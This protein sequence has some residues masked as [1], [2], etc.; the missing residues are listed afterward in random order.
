MYYFVSNILVKFCLLYSTPF[1]CG[2]AW[3][4]E[5]FFLSLGETS[6]PKVL[7]GW[8][9]DNNHTVGPKPMPKFINVILDS[10]DI[11]ESKYL[12]ILPPSYRGLQK[13]SNLLEILERAK[14]SVTASE[15]EH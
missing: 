4:V 14:F 9:L 7:L 3:V 15:G 13:Y 2:P 10:Y 11:F 6:T 12:V 1:C 5:G 8:D